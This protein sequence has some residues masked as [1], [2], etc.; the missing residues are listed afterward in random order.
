[1]RLEAILILA[2]ILVGGL[3]YYKD[4]G[5]S[6]VEDL[7]TGSGQESATSSD[8]YFAS[9]KG[10][11]FG[12]DREDGED[13]SDNKVATP[14]L[15]AQNIAPTLETPTVTKQVEEKHDVLDVLPENERENELLSPRSPYAGSATLKIGKAKDRDPD[16]EYLLLSANDTITISGWRLESYVTNSKATIPEGSALLEDRSDRTDGPIT[17]VSGET[18]YITTGETPLKTSFKENLCTGYLTEYEIFSPNL[19]KQCPMPGDELLRFANISASDDEC[20]E[21]VEGLRQCE[22]VDRDDARDADLSSRCQSFVES[23]FDYG[24]CVD[25]HRDDIDFSDI[26]VW[27]IYLDK[28]GELW[29]SAREIVRLLD[30]EGRVVA[31]LEY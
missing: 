29:L 1:M 15:Q 27:R 7:F 13:D 11:L 17:L 16:K 31:V 14:T 26:G 9:V 20:Y 21:F 18:A 28:N 19:K 30:N 23:T 5:F 12:D 8:S 22:V 2:L 4:G 3:I 6:S 25:R 10:W 24:E